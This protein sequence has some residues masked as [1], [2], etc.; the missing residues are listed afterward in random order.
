VSGKAVATIWQNQVELTKALDRVEEE[1]CVLGRLMIPKMNEILI[2]LGSEDLI[3]EESIN[4]VFLLWNEFKKR[5]DF[6]SHFVPWFLGVPLGELPLPPP[7]K[8]EGPADAPAP[9]DESAEEFGGDYGE[10]DDLRD[11]AAEEG[12]SQ[13]DED[14]AENALPK[15][16]DSDS[17]VPGEEQDGGAEMPQVL[18]SVQV[19]ERLTTSES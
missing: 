12:E 16:Q 8:K 11:A 18:D 9:K 15:G 6:K 19:Q 3:T 7:E 1:F 5:S 13:S 10:A 17:T 14:S 2:A 4:G